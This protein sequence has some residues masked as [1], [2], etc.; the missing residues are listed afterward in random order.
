MTKEEFTKAYEA[1]NAD[2]EVKIFA[3]TKEAGYAPKEIYIGRATFST[4]DQYTQDTIN[5]Y[6]TSLVGIYRI[7][8]S[9]PHTSPFR[10]TRIHA[11]PAL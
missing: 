4:A 8:E 2:K 6:G 9:A 5:T 3:K 1:K 11:G 7:Y 10:I